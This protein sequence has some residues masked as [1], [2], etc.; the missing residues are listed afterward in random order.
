MVAQSDHEAELRTIGLLGAE[1]GSALQLSL[2]DP[3]GDLSRG[4]VP[5]QS[6]ELRPLTKM[7]ASA[8]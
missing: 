1:Q 8:G 3:G 4:F 5:E 7:A 6:L 2:R